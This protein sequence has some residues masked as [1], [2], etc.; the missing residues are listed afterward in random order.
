M[1]KYNAANAM[2]ENTK[3]EAKAKAAALKE[4]SKE[5]DKFN[6]KAYEYIQA[7]KLVKQLEYYA[8]WNSI[9]NETASVAD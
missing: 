3:E 6:K 2:S 7:R 8:H 9:F 1:D 4:A 5:L